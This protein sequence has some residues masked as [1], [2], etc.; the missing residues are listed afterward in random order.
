MY[1]LMDTGKEYWKTGLIAGKPSHEQAEIQE[2]REV[3]VILVT[4]RDGRH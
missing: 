2:S 4:E 1:A 3:Y